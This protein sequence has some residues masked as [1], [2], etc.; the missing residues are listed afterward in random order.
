MAPCSQ[1]ADPELRMSVAVV[2]ADLLRSCLDV[3]WSPTVDVNSHN[4][5][6]SMSGIAMFQLL[7][8]GTSECDAYYTPI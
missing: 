1:D 6:T 2:R 5:P 8:M 4:A 7:R 3:H